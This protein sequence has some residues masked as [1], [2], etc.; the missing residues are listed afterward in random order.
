MF[1]LPD[2][3]IVIAFVLCLVRAGALVATAPLLGASF[4]TTPPKI[5]LSMALAFALYGAA[6][7]PAVDA[8]GMHL[9]VLVMR[10]L[11]IGLFLGFL[12]QLVLM[13]IRVMGEILGLEMGLQMANQVDPV[14]GISMPIVTRIYEGFAMLAL[15][16]IDAHHWVVRSLFDSIERAPLG[17]VASTDA[18]GSVFMAMSSEMLG[19][20][21]ALAAP[22]S[23][24]MSLVSILLGL[25]ARTAPQVNVLELGFTLRIAIAMVAMLVFS[26]LLGPM[27]DALFQSLAD[28]IEVGLDALEG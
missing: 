23:I 17:I 28:W 10:E 1:E 8:G 5:A 19:A 25:L 9:T 11:V 13:A 3:A 26:P 24:V 27:F 20:G 14:T 22:F 16:S 12:L 15:L 6:G 18:L 2:S 7:E 21:L 4:A